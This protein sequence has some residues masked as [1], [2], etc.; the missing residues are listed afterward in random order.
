MNGGIPLIPSCLQ[1]SCPM[2]IAGSFR[3]SLLSERA[4]DDTPLSSAEVAHLLS[5]NLFSNVLLL[6]YLYMDRGTL[7]RALLITRLS[8]QYTILKGCVFEGSYIIMCACLR[9]CTPAFLNCLEI[10]I[11]L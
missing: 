2:D 4:P 10:T 6:P 7:I 3:G 5:C 8:K 11:F 1:D 9:M